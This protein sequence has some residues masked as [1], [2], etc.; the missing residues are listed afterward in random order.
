MLRLLAAIALA[1][2][3]VAAFVQFGRGESISAFVSAELSPNGLYRVTLFTLFAKGVTYAMASLAL[4]MS[5]GFL[6]SA[7]ME[8]YEYPLLVTFGS[9]GAGM[10]L[11]GKRAL[12]TSCSARWRRACCCMARR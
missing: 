1:A 8:R 12:N 7:Q 6:K 10:M 11:S 9:L 2:A 5:G 4:F 3:A